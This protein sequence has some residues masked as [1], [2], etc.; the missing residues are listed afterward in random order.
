M[1]AVNDGLVIKL[2]TFPSNVIKEISIPIFLFALLQALIAPAAEYSVEQII[3]V[4]FEFFSI[5]FSIT[6]AT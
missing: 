6:E 3:A 2:T 1:I 4:I 5:F